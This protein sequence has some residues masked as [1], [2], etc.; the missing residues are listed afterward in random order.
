MRIENPF[1][2]GFG[3]AAGAALALLG[4]AMLAILAVFGGMAWGG[5]PGVLAFVVVLY[6]FGIWGGIAI[7]LAFA[8][9]LGIVQQGL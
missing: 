8:V 4:A 7:T 6:A 2:L 3:L 9:L 5:I 1:R